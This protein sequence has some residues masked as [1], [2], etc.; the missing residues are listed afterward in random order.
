MNTLHNP[1]PALVGLALALLLGGCVYEVPLTEEASVPIDP[2]LL[3]TWTLTETDNPAK[4]LTVVITRLSDTEYVVA[5]TTYAEKIQCY[6]AWPVELDGV[7]YLQLQLLYDGNPDLPA[8]IYLVG[9]LSLDGDQ[10]ALS[11]LTLKRHDTSSEDFRQALRENLGQP[12]LFKPV[13]TGLR[14]SS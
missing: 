14:A 10:L 8:Q 13:Y 5:T 4:T 6:R 1:L 11:L 9:Q 7:R 12:D 2:A 3:G